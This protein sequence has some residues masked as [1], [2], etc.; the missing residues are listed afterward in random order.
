MFEVLVCG[1]CWRASVA[2]G[3][4]YAD[5]AVGAEVGRLRVA[6]VCPSV[7]AAAWAPAVPAERLWVAWRRPWAGAEGW[8]LLER[9]WERLS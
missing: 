6:V 7:V 8:P 2:R 3:V 4:R 5:C 1:E 9:R